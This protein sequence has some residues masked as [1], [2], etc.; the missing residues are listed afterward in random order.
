MIETLEGIQSAFNAAQAGDKMIS[1]AD[2]IVLGGNVAIE[3]AAQKAGHSVE[4]PFSAGRGD[5]TQEQTDVDSFAV[6]EPASDGF[7][8]YLKTQYTLSA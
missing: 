6:L 5:A 1:V 7:R 2:L 3:Q 8:N 4:V